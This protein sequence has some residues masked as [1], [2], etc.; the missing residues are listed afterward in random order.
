MWFF[1]IIWFHKKSWNRTSIIRGAQCG[2]YGILLP[3]FFRKFSV[4]STFKE[5]YCKSIWRK[6]FAWQWIFRFS[7][8]VTL[9]QSHT[10]CGNYGT[11]LS[12]FF[13]QKFRENTVCTEK[14]IE[15][16]S[17]AI[18]K[19]LFIR[20]PKVCIPDAP[21]ISIFLR[22]LH[23]KIPTVNFPEVGT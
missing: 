7:H 11:L 1:F 13:L 14:Q 23:S 16:D 20:D 2:N 3:L 15:S 6:K 9:R 8:C 22:R 5:L 4:K 21:V 19:Y 10:Q 17:S 18:V 12:H